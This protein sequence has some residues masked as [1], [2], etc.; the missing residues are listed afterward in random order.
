MYCTLKGIAGMDRE[1]AAAERLLTVSED[2]GKRVALVPTSSPGWL[3]GQ[4]SY[5]RSSE[6]SEPLKFVDTLERLA[7]Q[8]VFS[9]LKE[10]DALQ[11]V[12]LDTTLSTGAVAEQL[13]KERLS[14]I[15]YYLDGASVKSIS[16]LE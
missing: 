11:A 6:D 9:S 8:R 12:I 10:Q 3:Y 15:K 5:K 4:C 1:K 14:Q 7:V 16:G 2:F 13:K